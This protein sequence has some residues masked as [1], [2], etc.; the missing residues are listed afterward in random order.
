MLDKLE[1][2]A[3]EL[4]AELPDASRER[5]QDEMGDLLFV[6]ANLA[7]KL[8]LDGEACLRAANAKFE[9]RFGGVE[10]RLAE[11]GRGPAEASLEEM[12]GLWGEVKAGER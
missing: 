8:G 3:A 10:A 4:R 2:E 5:L 7:R 9:R 11:A 1:E 6:C 12:E